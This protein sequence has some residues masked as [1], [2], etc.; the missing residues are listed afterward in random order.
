MRHP[1]ID[2]LIAAVA[3]TGV[4]SSFASLR[5]GEDDV[6]SWE[7]SLSMPV[8]R[9][10]KPADFISKIAHI[11]SRLLL[12]RFTIAAGPLLFSF[13]YDRLTYGLALQSR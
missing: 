3:S 7:P 5:S 6:R 2:E 13:I 4:R 10:Q 11:E 8:S 12:N 1:G 9:K